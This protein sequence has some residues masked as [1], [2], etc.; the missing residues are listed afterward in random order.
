MNIFNSCKKSTIDFI[1]KVSVILHAFVKGTQ[2]NK[3]HKILKSN[4]NK[5]ELVFITNSF[6]LVDFYILLFYFLR[7]KPIDNERIIAFMLSP[8]KNGIVPFIIT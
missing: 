8:N 5:K 3:K 1:K 7:I 6:I 4:S 2:N